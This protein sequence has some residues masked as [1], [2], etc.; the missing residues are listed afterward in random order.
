SFEK[1]A[2]Y[3]E[4][5]AEQDDVFKWTIEIDLELVMSYAFPP[6]LNLISS[7]DR[8][9][10]ADQDQGRSVKIVWRIRPGDDSMRTIARDVKEQIERKGKPG[11]DIEIRDGGLAKRR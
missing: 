6:L 9:V 10:K 5:R 3:L 1:A 11:A 4:A 8:L 7:L 2:A